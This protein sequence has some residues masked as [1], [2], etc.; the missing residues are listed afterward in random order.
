AMHYFNKGIELAPENPEVLKQFAIANCEVRDPGKAIDFFEKII[1]IDP[2]DEY[3][4]GLGLALLTNSQFEEGWKY[5]EYRLKMPN[6][7]YAVLKPNSPMWDGSSLKGKTIFI[8]QEQG[9]GDNIQFL[10][11][12][13]LLKK[14]FDCRIIL[15]CAANLRRI[16]MQFR[17]INQI[18]SETEII[19]DHDCHL[20]LLSLPLHLKINHPSQFMKDTPYIGVQPEITAFW[21][22]Y[23]AT[24]KKFKIGFCWSGSVEHYNNFRRNCDLMSFIKLLSNDNISLYSLQ[25]GISPSDAE[26]LSLSGIEDLG[27][28]F[29]DLADTAAA[30]SELDLIISIDSAIAHLAGALGK[31]TWVVLPYYVEWR[32]PYKNITSDWYL[33]T[34]Y[35][36]QEKPGDWNS[37]FAKI[38]DNLRNIAK[39]A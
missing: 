2:K 9:L 18:I 5:Y 38:D 25:K 6:H 12:I 26:L 16:A 32:H 35:I 21:R 28:M 3:K 27:E 30:I 17:D 33:N 1:K 4:F 7:I 36:R 39:K 15:G 13:P 10:R 29:D 11:F 19:P 14:Q 8:M 20:P 31:Q 34:T 22:N 37:V 23:L 24:N